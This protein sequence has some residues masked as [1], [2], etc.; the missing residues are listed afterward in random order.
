MTPYAPR[1]V[2]VVADTNIVVSGLLWEGGPPR[3]LI[4]A[5]FAGEIELYTSAVL[6]DELADV[7]TRAKFARKLSASALSNWCGA[8]RAWLNASDR[9][10]SSVSYRAIPMTTTCSPARLPPMSNSLISGDHRL[11]ALGNYRGIRIV[12]PATAITLIEQ[13]P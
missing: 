8:M 7:L 10:P 13:H 5:A 4:D 12:N 3:R 11:R 6:L 1:A 9:P 2:R